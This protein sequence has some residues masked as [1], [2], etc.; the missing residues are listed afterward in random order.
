MVLIKYSFK[1]NKS[2]SVLIKLCNILS[3]GNALCAHNNSINKMEFVKIVPMGKSMIS[4]LRS[5]YVI[6]LKTIIG[7]MF[8]VF[9]V[10]IHNIG[11][12]ET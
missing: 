10:T 8:N 1:N 11:I 2:A 4:S 12:L 6:R 5:V 7:I 3:M 9:Y